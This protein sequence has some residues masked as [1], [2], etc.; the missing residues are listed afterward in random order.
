MDGWMREEVENGVTDGGIRA[1][2]PVLL[3]GSGCG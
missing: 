1:S 2:V 3:S